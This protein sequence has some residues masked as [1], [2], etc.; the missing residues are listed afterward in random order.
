MGVEIRK[1]NIDDG[2]DVYEMLQIMPRDENGFI[3][4]ANGKSYEEYQ[5][6]L[7]DM[8]E[9]ALQKV[10]I[11]G[12]KVPE[13]VYWL[14]EDGKP[15]GFGK[16]RHFLTE[17]LTIQGGNIGYAIAPYARRK[18]LGTKF[19]SLL[20]DEASKLG[21]ERILLTIN[22][23]NEPSVKVA[24]ANGGVVDNIVNERYRIWIDL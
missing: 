17:A 6:W 9:C 13:S 10:I 15:V 1:L 16:I 3:N 5:K 21:V 12:W 22:V 7:T 20:K 8:Y 4:S 14:Y 23:D 19:L 2:A 18:G 24:L 11:D